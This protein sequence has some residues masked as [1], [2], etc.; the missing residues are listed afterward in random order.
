MNMQ[1]GM[2]RRPVVT[3]D[4]NSFAAACARLM[5]VACGQ[6]RPQ[7]IVGIPTGGMFV[8]EAMSDAASYLPVFPLTCRRPSTR[9]KSAPGLK[10]LVRSLPRPLLDRLRLIEHAILTR[11]P[12]APPAEGSF[13][14]DEQELAHLRDAIEAA[15]PKASILV[16]DD[17]VDTGSTMSVVM[18]AVRRLAPDT[19]IIRSA[20][21]TVTTE[22]PLISPDHALYSR[23]L[24]RFPWSLDA[25]IASRS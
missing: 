11:R 14:I 18:G 24:C 6:E 20:A 10:S 5:D 22:N 19:A 12:P 25:T 2:T 13:R 21:I 17:A 7:L 3:F 4:R 1:F 8:A 16:V 23:Q 15:G 9:H